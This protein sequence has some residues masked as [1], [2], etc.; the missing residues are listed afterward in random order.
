MAENYNL[1]EQHGCIV[2]GKIHSMLVV[3]SASDKMIDCTVTSPGGRVVPDK[4]RPLVSC[5]IH[6]K[7]EVD[8]ALASHYPGMEQKEDSEE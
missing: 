2:C 7:A 5:N 4:L 1:V 3:Y 8:N 6:S